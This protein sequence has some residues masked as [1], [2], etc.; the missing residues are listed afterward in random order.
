MEYLMTAISG[1]L[2]FALA[3]TC[4]VMA[5]YVIFE[6]LMREIAGDGEDC[7]GDDDCDDY[8]DGLDWQREWVDIG[9]EG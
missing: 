1:L 3:I 8:D 6:P 2:L 4:L 5:G 9:G 7:D